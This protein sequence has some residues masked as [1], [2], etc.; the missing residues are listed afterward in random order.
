MLTPTEMRTVLKQREQD[1]DKLLLQQEAEAATNPVPS[2]KP[3]NNAALILNS[4]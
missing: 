3:A 2:V 1:A 4:S